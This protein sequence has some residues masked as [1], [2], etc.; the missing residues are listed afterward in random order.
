MSPLRRRILRAGAVVVA[1]LLFGLVVWFVNGTM[2]Q[3]DQRASV[4]AMLVSVG[5]LLLALYPILRAA[6]PGIEGVDSRLVADHLA[7]ELLRQWEDEAR[8]RDLIDSPV[9][10]LTWAAA[11]ATLTDEPE[12]P[13]RGTRPVRVRLDGG[14]SASPTELADRFLQLPG[15]RLVVLGEPGA[16]KSVLALLLTLGLLRRRA[17]GAAVPVLFQ[18]ASWDPFREN[19]EDWIIRVLASDYYNGQERFARALVVHRLIIP[20]LDGLD[21]I[22][23]NRRAFAIGELN[24]IAVTDPFIATSRV[25]EYADVVTE[26]GKL[27]ST[28]VVEI[29]SVDLDDAIGYLTALP[30]PAGTDWG[31]VCDRMREDPDSP[32]ARTF[33]TPLMISLAQDIYMKGGDPGELLDSAKFPTRQSVEDAL[34]DRAIPAAYRTAP[35]G[36]PAE[37]ERWNGEDAERWLTFLATYLQGTHRRTLAWWRICGEIHRNTTDWIIVLTVGAVV[38]VASVSLARYFGQSATGFGDTLLADLMFPGAL[39]LLGVTYRWG[40]TIF[41]EPYRLAGNHR[42]LPALAG[43]LIGSYASF[44]CVGFVPLIVFHLVMNSEPDRDLLLFACVGSALLMTGALALAVGGWTTAAP[45][46]VGHAGPSASLRDDLVSTLVS[47]VVAGLVAVVVVRAF[48]FVQLVMTDLIWGTF[49][50][51]TGREMPESWFL[52]VDYETIVSRPNSLLLI[53]TVL[54]VF[55]ALVGRASPKFLTTLV[56]LASR[57]SVPWSLMPFLE[58]ARRRGLLRRNGG[59]YEFRHGKLQ[60]RLATRDAVRAEEGSGSRSSVGRLSVVALLLVVLAV[61]P[62]ANRAR[63]A[64]TWDLGLDARLKRVPSADGSICVGVLAESEWER[65]TLPEGSAAED[66]AD[67]EEVFD[68]LRKSNAEA[69]RARERWTAVVRGKLSVPGE[70]ARTAL[71]ERLRGLALAQRRL[72]AAGRP[73]VVVLAT[74]GTGEEESVDLSA[75]IA[76]LVREDPRLMGL[77]LGPFTH[78][79]NVEDHFREPTAHFYSLDG[80]GSL[81]RDADFSA[82]FIAGSE[83]S[84]R[85]FQAEFPGRVPVTVIEDDYADPYIGLNRNGDFVQV[86]SS[87]EGAR[88]VCRSGPARPL[89]FQ[90]ES[91]QVADF[92]EGLRRHC[93]GKY[94]SVVVTNSSAVPQFATLDFPAGLRVFYPV[95]AS[96]RAWRDCRTVGFFQEYERLFGAG[97]TVC[98]R[99]A[100]G[101][102]MIAHDLLTLQADVAFRTGAGGYDPD[103]FRGVDAKRPVVGV[104]GPMYYTDEVDEYDQ[105]PDVRT[106]LMMEVNG[107]TSGVRFVCGPLTPAP[108]VTPAPECGK[109][110]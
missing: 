21:E 77:D 9:I 68:L 55:L 10:R 1:V 37:P 8:S 102:A 97:D 105:E 100:D 15:R 60:E 93:A 54:I 74:Q 84:A 106:V 47:T 4:I 83:V 25:R 65:L 41:V 67:Y 87:D 28:P 53:G 32:P 39:V 29:A 110:S 91:D 88:Q 95:L 58:D 80:D 103:L 82:G 23:D 49:A 48:A 81:V 69:G 31:P 72:L 63:C 92:M 50:G 18:A 101:Q 6:P 59:S 52:A 12:L 2:E 109:N 90:A 79:S 7:A 107:T 62:I 45:P 70:A 75:R 61:T 99:T 20:I 19:F 51:L 78:L 57:K 27:R 30:W 22:P 71:L 42:A 66:V 94:P 36:T 98:A 104:A 40:A 85:F 35:G 16:G 43:R 64:D 26:L 46:R 108:V 44:M 33:S 24:K 5:A 76:G 13:R 96:S 73:V 34:L 86:P 3:N 56:I 17:S 14:L 89:A 11:S 38:T